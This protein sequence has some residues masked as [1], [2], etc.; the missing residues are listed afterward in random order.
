MLI[1]VSA[2]DLQRNLAIYIA[3]DDERLESFAPG[4]RKV[5]DVRQTQ[6]AIRAAIL[7]YWGEKIESLGLSFAKHA[8]LISGAERNQRLYWLVFASRSDFAVG[9]WDK[10]RN[11]SGQA[12]L[13]L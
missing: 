11:I 12:D 7:E 1:H 4:W 13:G 10:I 8:A 5:V 2:Q 3:P 6:P 9:L